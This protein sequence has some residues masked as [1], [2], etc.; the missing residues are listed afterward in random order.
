MKLNK[1]DKYKYCE[2]Y[3]V[4]GPSLSAIMLIIN[5]FILEFSILV[6]AFNISGKL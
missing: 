4:E 6:I 3:K 2:L 5:V 1:K